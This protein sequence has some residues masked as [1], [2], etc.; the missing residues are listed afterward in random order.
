MI[1]LQ[2][3]RTMEIRLLQTLGLLRISWSRVCVPFK[4]KTMQNIFNFWLPF[5]N[6]SELFEQRCYGK[7]DFQSCRQRISC[8]LI[9]FFFNWLFS[10]WELS[11]QQHIDLGPHTVKVWS[12]NHWKAREFSVLLILKTFLHDR[13]ESLYQEGYIFL[14]LAVPVTSFALCPIMY[15]RRE[16]KKEALLFIY[17]CIYEM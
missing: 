6:L 12:P 8:L 5:L 15:A 14:L 17:T 2:N 4:K 10:F 11:P 9:Y 1:R 7:L 3:G 16:K 13:L